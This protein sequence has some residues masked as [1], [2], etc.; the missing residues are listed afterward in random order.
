MAAP[1]KSLCSRCEASV[2]CLT[3][4]QRFLRSS[5]GPCFILGGTL[6][7]FTPYPLHLTLGNCHFFHQL[8]TES[9]CKPLTL[10][11]QAAPLCL[12]RIVSSSCLSLFPTLLQ[13]FPRL[14]VS[15]LTH[16]VSQLCDRYF[17]DS[18]CA[19]VGCLLLV[20]TL[21]LHPSFC[22]PQWPSVAPS[23]ALSLLV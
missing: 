12:E 8:V 1:S 16:S 20:F 2:L 17:T 6:S 5:C 19:P 21:L 10:L 11:L 9:S 7:L 22:S 18:V 4:S 14:T 13:Q 15:S 23:L 3:L